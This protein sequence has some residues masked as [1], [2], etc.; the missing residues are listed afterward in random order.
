MAPVK[1]FKNAAGLAD[2][3]TVMKRVPSDNLMYLNEDFGEVI[4]NGTTGASEN[5]TR[6]IMS[7]PGLFKGA[8]TNMDP[9]DLQRMFDNMTL[10]S[11]VDFYKRADDLILDKIEVGDDVITAGRN[12]NVTKQ[13]D[14]FAT[15]GGDGAIVKYGSPDFWKAVST[16]TL[17]I[18]GFALLK[19]IDDKFE[20]AEEEYKNCMA[21]C[22][23]HN[24]DAF[25]QGTIDKDA[26]LYSNVAS[27]EEYQ[28]TPVP[29]QPYCVKPN[30]KCEEYCDP[31][32]SEL[33]E[34]DLPFVDSPL[35][36]F[37]PD[38]PLNPFKWF[39]R[40]LSAFNLDFDPK[41]V[42]GASSVSSL[43]VIALIVMSM[44]MK[45]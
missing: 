9:V 41:L 20:D 23:P 31:K 13:G 3:V 38:S 32:C 24:W 36:P 19:W 27:L 14:D 39:E 33:S 6:L 25:D 42:S 45:K 43:A 8:F 21:G 12:S 10:T 35:N 30:D 40:L 26:L 17:V 7:D 22:L 28:I 5:Y 15:T 4:R 11:K 1:V 34:V 18:A 29:S 37:N 16:G 2:A 44:V